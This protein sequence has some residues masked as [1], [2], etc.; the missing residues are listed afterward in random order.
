MAAPPSDEVKAVV[1]RESPWAERLWR[2]AQA[3]LAATLVGI[4]LGA[5]ARMP[6]L[7][8]LAH[9]LGTPSTLLLGLASLVLQRRNRGEAQ[10]I[11]ASSEG[12]RLR[13]GTLVPRSEIT[14]ATIKPRQPWNPFRYWVQNIRLLFGPAEAEAPEAYQ[15]SL[16]RKGLFAWPLRFV[17]DRIEEAR[18][19]LD[20]LRLGAAHRAVTRKVMSPVLQPKYSFGLVVGLWGVAMVAAVLASQI[21]AAGGLFALF[22]LGIFAYLALAIRRTRVT[23]GADGVSV[24]WLG[25]AKTV[26]LEEITRVETAPHSIWTPARV[27]LHQRKGPPLEIPIGLRGGN[28]FEPYVIA[29]ETALIA[30]RIQE[31]MAKGSA[32]EPTEFRVWAEHRRALEPKAWVDTLRGAVEDYRQGDVMPFSTSELWAVVQNVK[33]TAFERTLAVVALTAKPDEAVKA[34]LTEVAQ[35][36]ALPKL[37]E[38]LDAAARGDDPALTSVLAELRT[39]ELERLRSA[40][41]TYP[42]EPVRVRVETAQGETA[43]DDEAAREEREREQR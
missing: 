1:T 19:I 33:A 32:A 43:D 9:A 8:L 25:K 5:A 37:K 28:P 16:S 13:D 6:E 22:P 20:A 3:T 18:A 42:P 36:T 30:E 40:K 24:Q 15:V 35:S 21:P 11:E 38:A 17:V 12:L 34:R 23:I 2:A 41:G 4:T 29:D 26:R 31:A 7:A 14:E 39:E 27:V 10:T